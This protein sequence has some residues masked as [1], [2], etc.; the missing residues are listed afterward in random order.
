MPPTPSSI[1][2][3]ALNSLSKAANLALTTI[4][5]QA[6][7]DVA[8]ANADAVEARRERDETRTML[9]TIQLEQKEWER[10]EEGWKAAIDKSDITI[11]HQAETIARL[12]A[13]AAQWKTQ[14]LRLEETSR[15]ESLDWKEQ[16]FRAEQERCRLSHRV[17]ELVAEQLAWNTQ[18]NASTGSNAPLTPRTPHPDF[19]EPSTS[20]TTTKRASTSSN[21]TLPLAP[22]KRATPLYPA[23]PVPDGVEGELLF[24]GRKPARTPSKPP[25]HSDS[26]QAGSARRADPTPSRPPKQKAYPEVSIPSSGKAL[27]TPATHRPPSA[28]RTTPRDPPVQQ[29]PHQHVIRRVRAVIEVPVKDEDED[30]VEIPKHTASVMRTPSQSGSDEE[31]VEGSLYEPEERP[32]K[33]QTRRA[34]RVSTRGRM[35]RGQ[36]WEDDR[37]EDG[38]PIGGQILRTRR[39]MDEESDDDVDELAMSAEENADHYGAQVVPSVQKVPRTSITRTAVSNSASAKKRKL[40]AGTSTGGNVGGGRRAT[41]KVARKK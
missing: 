14:K 12:R 22:H 32:R 17:D 38:Y 1:I 7:T 21:T 2:S 27:R 37:E 15:Q 35:A 33:R 23:K 8:R 6:R 29:T 36:M 24:S 18:A 25:S 31:S 4:E 26:V 41:A 11:K 28:S 10:R 19:F 34:P 16:Y 13:E 3:D 40:D 20:S 9:H 5:D 30:D 39:V